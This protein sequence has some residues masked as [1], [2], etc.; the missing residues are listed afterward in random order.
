MVTVPMRT[1]A[2]L[3]HLRPVLTMSSHVITADASPKC[4][5]VM[6]RMIAAMGQMNATAVSLPGFSV[7][8][9]FTIFVDNSGK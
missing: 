1:T 2:P 5:C 9:N 7:L 8:Q 3:K 6:A 4:G